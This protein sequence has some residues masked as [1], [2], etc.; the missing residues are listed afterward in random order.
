MKFVEYISSRLCVDSTSD[1][2]EPFSHIK[3]LDT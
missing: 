3:H 2:F 1:P